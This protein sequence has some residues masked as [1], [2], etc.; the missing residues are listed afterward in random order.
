MNKD[1]KWGRPEAVIKGLE[2]L[3]EALEQMKKIAEMQRDDT[4]KALNNAVEYVKAEAEVRESYSEGLQE[5][6]RVMKQR[7]EEY[8]RSLEE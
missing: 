8:K 4:M 5:K 7:F 3:T 6:E 2:G 1:I